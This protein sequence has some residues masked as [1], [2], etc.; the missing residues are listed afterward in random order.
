MS[1]RLAILRHFIATRWLPAPGPRARERRRRRFLEQARRQSP[2]YRGREDFPILTKAEFLAHF[3]GLNTRGITLE[4]A[5][6]LALRAERER[7]FSAEL[8]GG[9]TVGLSSGT[10]GS[11]HVFLVSREERCRWAG[12]MFGNMLESASL[13]QL[14]NP[15]APPLR[16]AFFLRASSRLYTTLASRRLRFD[17]YDLLRPFS[18]LM[19]ELCA[20]PP[21]LLVAPATVLAAM[22]RAE[23]PVRPR[24]VLSVAEVLDV[25]DRAAIETH[26]GVRVREIYQATEGFLGSQCEAGSLHLNEESLHIEPLWIDEARERFH[27][28]I[29]DFS[30]TTQWFIRYRLD[31]LLTIEPGDCP[32]GRKT[33][34]L[35]RIE[36]RAEEVLWLADAGG[37][38]SPVFPDV[39]RRALY[40]CENPPQRYRIEQHGQR[41][42]LRQLGG[43][44]P[45]VSEAIENLLRGLN[46]TPPELVFL[47]WTDQHP[48]EKEKRI[49]CL[50]RPA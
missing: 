15:F 29:T 41:W 9:I 1:E 46:L 2:F 34:R 20:R 25:R 27:P 37:N 11:R 50:E 42:E 32:C 33:T 21:D 31:D 36:G 4:A 45:A 5:T 8:P 26:F 23:V 16:L 3:A 43:S 28:L 10:S 14:L 24:Q 12:Q 48:G 39:L 6:D 38:L 18:E 22:A 47:P 40:A 49:R 44:E 30:R 19:D 17:Y 7:D 35:R 13:R